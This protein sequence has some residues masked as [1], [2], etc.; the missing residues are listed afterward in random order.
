MSDSPRSVSPFVQPGELLG[1]PTFFERTTGK[2]P[3][4]WSALCAPFQRLSC[5]KPP[6]RFR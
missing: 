4:P 1:Y 2:P 5:L 6:D 3:Y